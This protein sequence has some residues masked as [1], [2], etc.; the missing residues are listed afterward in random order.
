VGYW[1]KLPAS[2]AHVEIAGGPAKEREAN[3]KVV[4]MV[5]NPTMASRAMWED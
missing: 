4:E 2:N 3:G 1:E 5:L